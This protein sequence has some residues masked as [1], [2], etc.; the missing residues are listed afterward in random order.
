M[1]VILYCIVSCLVFAGGVS[2]HAAQIGYPVLVDAVGV[3]IVD[4]VNANQKLHISAN[5]SNTYETAQ[6]FAYIVQV[7]DQNGTIVMLKWFLGEL[8]A[9][10]SIDIATSW[11]PE[12]PSL[13]VIDVFLWD[14]LR[15]Q[16]ALDAKKSATISVS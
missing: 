14:G 2:A 6:G 9:G 11:T 3:P 13:Y 16:N 1:M 15:T 4:H 5:I 8:D 7:T 10:Q 12:S